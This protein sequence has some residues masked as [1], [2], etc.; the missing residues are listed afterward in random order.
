MELTMN[1][2]LVLEIFSVKGILLKS[3]KVLEFK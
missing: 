2:H 1:M 3:L